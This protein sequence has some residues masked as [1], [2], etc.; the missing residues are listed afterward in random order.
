MPVRQ[1]EPVHACVRHLDRNS[2][3]T[4]DA[5]DFRI[6]S[7]RSL[8]FELA[9]IVLW[10]RRRKPGTS[11][12]R[13]IASHSGTENW[14]CH[15]QCPRST[16]NRHSFVTTTRQPNRTKKRCIRPQRSPVFQDFEPQ[17]SFLTTHG[18]NFLITR[19]AFSRSKTTDERF[20]HNCSAPK[21]RHEI[22]HA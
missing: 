17:P 14:D 4:R 20:E 6:G 21:N 11:S 1:R 10:L 5:P 18:L 22:F 7:N 12:D 16:A 13:S 2:G 15:R 3:T 8:H 19:P 9:S